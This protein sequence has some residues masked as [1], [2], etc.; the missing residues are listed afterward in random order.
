MNIEF[1]VIG[2]DQAQAILSWCYASPYDFYNFKPET[3]H[4]DLSYMLDPKNAFF[5]ILNEHK[6]LEGFCSFGKDGQVLGGS[7]EAPAL[8]IGF[9]LRPDLTGKGKGRGYAESVVEYGVSRYRAIFLR[10]TVAT[11]NQ[12]ALRVWRYLNFEPA[13]TFVSPNSGTE[14]VT[15]TREADFEEFSKARVD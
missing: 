4:S 6:T 8:D 10:V 11:F 13:E 7:Y 1:R 14:F 5:A 15:M 9:G 12:R 2:K 3:H